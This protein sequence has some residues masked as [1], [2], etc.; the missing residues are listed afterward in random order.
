MR[1]INWFKKRSKK[2]INWFKKRSKK[3]KRN[4]IQNGPDA[5]KVLLCDQIN[6]L[7]YLANK[8]SV[9]PVLRKEIN[10]FCNEI[11]EKIK[12]NNLTSEDIKNLNEFRNLF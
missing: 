4:I 7:H 12:N 8:S 6:S 3:D 5:N 10:R 1:L 9:N 2:V 11:I